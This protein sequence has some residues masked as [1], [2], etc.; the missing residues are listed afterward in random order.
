MAN[1][2][3]TPHPALRR[4]AQPGN[5]NALRN[6][7]YSAKSL[8]AR[9]LSVAR[10]KALAHAVVALKLLREKHRHRIAP[11]RPDQIEMLRRHDPQLLGDVALEHR[12]AATEIA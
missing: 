8:L 4:G 12:V 5:R 6:G 9:K 7:R 10:L 3:D 11:L 1:E 2:S